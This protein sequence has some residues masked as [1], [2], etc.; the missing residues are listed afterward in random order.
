MNVFRRYSTR[1]KQRMNMNT[2]TRES[3]ACLKHISSHVELYHKT[4]NEEECVYRTELI[5][6]KRKHEVVRRNHGYDHD[7]TKL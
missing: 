3:E 4:C 5:M 6:K 1:T 2:R 7:N